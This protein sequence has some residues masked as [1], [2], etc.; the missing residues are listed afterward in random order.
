M[1]APMSSFRTVSIDSV[2]PR[3]GVYPDAD[4]PAL[5]DALGVRAQGLL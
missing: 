3:S 5:R 2:K 1:L 4:W